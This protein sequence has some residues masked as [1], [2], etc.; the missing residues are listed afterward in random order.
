MGWQTFHELLLYNRFMSFC[1]CFN[2]KTQRLLSDIW[3]HAAPVIHFPLL[4]RKDQSFTRRLN[5]IL[6]HLKV[7]GTTVMLLQHMYKKKQTRNRNILLA[8]HCRDKLAQKTRTTDQSDVVVEQNN[9]RMNT[10]NSVN[11]L[12]AFKDMKSSN[13]KQSPAHKNKSCGPKR[14][15]RNLT[16]KHLSQH[17]SFNICSPPVTD[18][19]M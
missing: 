16:W 9:I 11:L 19:Q 13:L 10:R 7:A 2:H 18:L 12:I 5:S 8:Q 1:I 17:I 4:V 6:A 15:Q 3:H 14:L